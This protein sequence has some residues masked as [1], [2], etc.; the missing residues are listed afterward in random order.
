MPLWLEWFRC[1]SLL[2]PACARQTTFLWM[3][4]ALAGLSIRSELAGVTSFVRALWLQPATYRRLLH[5]FHSPALD[6]GQ[7]TRLWMR[8][9]LVLFR[10]LTLGQRIVFL[11]DG[12]KVPKEGKKMPAVKKLH[13][14]S[15]DNTK[16]PFIFGHSFQAVSLLAKGLLGQPFAVPLA[17]RI[18]EG[19][20]FS[21]RD[22]RTL[23]DKLVALF[24][25]LVGG[26]GVSAILVADAYYAS[27]K[28]ILP[29]M[30]EGHHL[31]TRARINTTAWRAPPRP[32]VRRRGRPRIYGE[33]VHLRDLFHGKKGF[34]SAA[35]PVY[36]EKGIELAYRCVD[37]LWRP[38][39]RLVRFVLVDHPQRG[40]IILMCSDLS[41][42]P[43]QVIQLYGYRFKIEL[44][45]KQALHTLGAYAY[46]FWMMDMTPI[47]RRRSGNQFLHMKSEEYR[48]HVR[49]KLAAY[50][51][52]VQL[53]CIAQGLQ[54]HLAVDFR[55]GVWDHFKSW[56]RT[57]KPGLP[58]SEAVV[59]QALRANLDPFLV[60]A[61]EHHPLRK[62]I[63]EHLDCERCPAMVLA[64]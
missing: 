42:E 37:L 31:I 7:L 2:R 57:M 22:K 60:A 63:L 62:F 16:P 56:M 23:L 61:P 49:R 35:S 53:A 46:H 28:V 15:S 9:A 13:Q 36:G 52:Y 50:H 3:S 11:A 30:L 19:L 12:I 54:Q 39:G 32:K 43:L 20:V 8:L 59:A 1:V 5:F 6:L 48:Q 47:S 33:K 10:P 17:S 44:G 24:L 40:R 45:F 29:L 51:R 25:E 41:I 21:N 27:R 38:V 64:G 55:T 4:L 58:P 18:H 14:E 34:V 26:A